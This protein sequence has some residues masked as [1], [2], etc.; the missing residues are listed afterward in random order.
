MFQLHQNLISLK[1]RVGLD[2]LQMARMLYHL[3]DEKNW[4]V[5]EPDATWSGYCAS[6][7]LGI[8]ES[9]A[10]NLMRIYRKFVI[11]LGLSEED[12]VGI[13]SRKLSMILPA[14]T[15]D[16]VSELLSR[17]RTL[18]RSD[19]AISLEEDKVGEHEHEIEVVTYN[20][21]KKCKIRIV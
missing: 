12:L 8:S 9:S 19:L 10:G 11:D 7:E 20:R 5:I 13:D 4:H 14:V 2:S 18:S 17:A 16:T 1:R 6:P 3:H 21:C 15:P